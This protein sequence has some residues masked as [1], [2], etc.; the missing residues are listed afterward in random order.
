MTAEVLYAREGR[1][2]RILLNRPRTINVLNDVM[3]ASVLETAEGLG[4]R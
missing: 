2:G 3:V 4:P 1:L